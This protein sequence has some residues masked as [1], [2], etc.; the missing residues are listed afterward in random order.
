M[1]IPDIR[2]DS[3]PAFTAT[4]VAGRVN[5]LF[6]ARPDFR[7]RVPELWE[8]LA[9]RSHLPDDQP[10]IGVLDLS[11]GPDPVFTYLAGMETEHL[12]SQASLTTLSVPAQNYV[13]ISFRGPM[14]SLA[15]VLRWF[16]RAWLPHA[17]CE[18]LYGFDLE[19]YPPGF[20]PQA[21]EVTMEY[22]VPVRLSRPFISAHAPNG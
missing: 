21:P 7:K 8:Q 11:A 19:V 15:D 3:R 17:G 9:R 5:G 16:F 2:L 18:A 1:K 14:A 12:P 13:V 10:R 20:D 4:G 6:S 22:W